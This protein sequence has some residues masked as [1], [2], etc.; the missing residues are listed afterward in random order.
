ML[1]VDRA[2]ERTPYAARIEDPAY[3]A[4]FAAGPA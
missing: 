1:D 3:H 2:L 4:S